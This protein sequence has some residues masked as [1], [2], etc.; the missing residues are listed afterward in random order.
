LKSSSTEIEG[1]IEKAITYF[2]SYFSRPPLEI[3][4]DELLQTEAPADL[5]ANIFSAYDKFLAILD[6]E[7][8][9][10]E[11]EKIPR[12]SA[13]KSRV[14]QR[15]RTHSHEFRDALLEWLYLP[16]TPLCDMVKQYALF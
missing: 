11:L 9:R 3:L 4:A 10:Y 7:P 5:S 13:D 1:K 6:D 2:E 12:E 16:K 8:S 15:I 14:F